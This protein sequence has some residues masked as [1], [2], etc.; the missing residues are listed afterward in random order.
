MAKSFK[1]VYI[2][3]GLFVTI[4]TSFIATLIMGLIYSFSP[5]LESQ[6]H[7]LGI[8]ALSVLFGSFYTTYNLGAKG[9]VYGLLVGLCFFL[10]TLL[11]Y[12]FFSDSGSSLSIIIERLLICLITGAFGGT[13][14]VICKK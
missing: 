14:G 8:L 10:F 12:Y 6:I 2:L 3:R 9:L 11:I 7:T 5:V 13:M 4:L 1:G